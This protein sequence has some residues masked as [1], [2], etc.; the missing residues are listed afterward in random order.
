MVQTLRT[1]GIAHFPGILTADQCIDLIHLPTAMH[2]DDDG[3]HAAHAKTLFLPHVAEA[4]SGPLL[5]LDLSPHEAVSVD[6]MMKA[7][8]L[9]APEGAVP[10]HV[11]EDFDGPDGTRALYSV[12]VYL[13]DRYAG[14]QTLFEGGPTLDAHAAGDVLVFRH[15]IR[16]EAL[17]V[18]SGVKHVLKTDLYVR[19]R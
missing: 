7:Y 17:A 9:E 10:A 1:S 2:H 16:H 3:G 19:H 5:G 12:I 18:T 11:D 6:Q 14:G 13:N 4:L 8:R 15:D